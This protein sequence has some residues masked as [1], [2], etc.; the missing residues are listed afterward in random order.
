MITVQ[1][2]EVLL[3]NVLLY[4]S[5]AEK[6]LQLIFMFLIIVLIGQCMEFWISVTMIT[7]YLAYFAYLVFIG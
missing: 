3:L 1:S 7:C 6:C 4:S 5:E 2:I